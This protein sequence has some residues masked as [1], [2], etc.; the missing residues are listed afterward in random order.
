MEMWWDGSHYW[1]VALE[2]YKLP[3]GKADEEGEVSLHVREQLES[4]ELYL[5]MDAEQTESFWVRIKNQT[6]INGT[7]VGVCYG[8][9][10]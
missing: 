7:V 8:Q 9:T 1:S 4:I 5:R 3:G 6:G 10:Y 2:E